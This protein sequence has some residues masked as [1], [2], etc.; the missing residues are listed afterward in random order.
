MACTGE[1]IYFAVRR[2]QEICYS[3]VLPSFSHCSTSLGPYFIPAPP[4]PQTDLFTSSLPVHI[5][6][7]LTKACTLLQ[8]HILMYVHVWTHTFVFISVLL[9]ILWW[10]TEKENKKYHVAILFSFTGSLCLV[11]I[12]LIYSTMQRVFLNL[13][14]DKIRNQ[15]RMQLGWLAVLICM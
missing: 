1:C 15:I 7:L 10:Y 8:T 4:H 2:H 5:Y 14:G 9:C 3:L 11:I 13:E 6:P 12:T